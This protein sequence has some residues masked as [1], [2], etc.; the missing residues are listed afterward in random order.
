MVVDSFRYCRLYPLKNT[1]S[2]VEYSHHKS[3][4]DSPSCQSMARNEAKIIK[5]LVNV[6]TTIPPKEIKDVHHTEFN[7]IFQKQPKTRM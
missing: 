2:E 3:C 5:E 1:V 4:S 7:I 6:C